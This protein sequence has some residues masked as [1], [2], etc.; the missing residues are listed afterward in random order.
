MSH[1]RSASRWLYPLLSL[2]LLLLVWE[3]LARGDGAT[4][5]LF[6]SLGSIGSALASDGFGLARAAGQTLATAILGFAL[7]AS[8]GA[9]AAILCSL[10]PLIRDGLLPWLLALQLMPVVVL[11]PI[12]QVLLGPGRTTVI[13][14]AAII[15]FF[16]VFLNTWRGLRSVPSPLV[17]LFRFHRARPVEELW[18][19]RLPSALPS[20]L[21]GLT[22]AASLALVGAVTAE[23]LSGT[24]GREGGLGY[25]ILL[26]YARVDTAG[27]FAAALWALFLGLAFVGLVR[28]LGGLLLR[29]WLP[30]PSQR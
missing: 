27:L 17:D 20:F 21:T 13:L 2:A 23:L 10:Y 7:A 18:L 24:V 3:L 29:R 9:G 1:F 19:L 11:I 30:P 16:P 5:Y 6:P 8:F 28:G 25:R 4:R 14:I 12:F 22:I 26:A 15:S